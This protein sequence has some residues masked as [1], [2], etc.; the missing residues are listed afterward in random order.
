MDKLERIDRVLSGESV[1]R[2]PLS[3][4]YHF[5]VQH[6]TG[7]QFARIALEFF[8]HYDFDFLKVMN[9]YFY[10]L[11]EGLDAIRTRADLERIQPIDIDSC[12]WRH[13]FSALELIAGSLKDRAYF[14]D[15]VFD[16]WQTLQRH[17]VGAGLEHL[18]SEAPGP[19]K[20]A[21]DV[22]TDA[23][24]AY[25]RRSLEIGSA[26]I[27]VSIPAA[28]EIISHD[29]FME[30]VL[31]YT[32][33]LLRAISGIGILNTAHIHGEH[34]F[35]DDVI[36]L[37]A[38]VFSW[39]DRSKRGPALKSIK[40]RIRGCVMGGIDQTIVSR[41]SPGFLKEHV[42]EG[43]KL[44]GARRFILAGGCS[45]PSWTYPGSIRAIVD[46]ARS[47]ESALR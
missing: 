31:P 24:I 36:D 22:V 9:D 40:D 30:F 18:M 23:L 34:L 38:A 14:I 5:G 26:G 10:P 33:R 16:P 11:P 47:A 37:P 4:W 15:T 39:W 1:D 35:F 8:E 3:L 42:K 13:Q 21:L 28:A 19:L 17:M 2:P 27:F 20:Q 25:S 41:S 6:G 46:A 7:D 32:T 45:I 29:R 44:G 43:I 12:D